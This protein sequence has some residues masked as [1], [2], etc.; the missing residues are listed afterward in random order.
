MAYG[1]V[2]LLLTGLSLV[3]VIRALPVLGAIERERAEVV[4]WLDVSVDSIGDVEQ[5]ASRA[6]TSLVSAAA[7]ARSAASLSDELSGT[8]ASLRDT[9]GTLSIL[10]TR[11]LSGLT[12]DFDRVA[13]RAHELAA[14]MTSLARSLDG[15]TVDFA[16][17]A[18]DATA[19]RIQVRELRD[20]VAGD[21]SADVGGSLGQLFVV[22]LLLLV[23][24]AL[25]AGASLAVGVA[26]LRAIGRRPVAG[27]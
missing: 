22:V 18:A 16:T 13:G 24:L 7:S 27:G 15:N 17:V 19:L 21:G 14:T 9:S 8:M 10:G 1:S 12:A 20:L 26:W 25:P 3:L 2:G 4:R 5:G 6:R 23:W 11:P